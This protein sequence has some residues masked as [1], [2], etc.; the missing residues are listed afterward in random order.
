MKDED[1]KSLEILIKQRDQKISLP[2]WIMIN[3]PLSDAIYH[4]GQIVLLRRISGNPINPNVD[5]F[6]GKNKKND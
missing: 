5:I 4:T 6:T 3:G 2:L 1:F